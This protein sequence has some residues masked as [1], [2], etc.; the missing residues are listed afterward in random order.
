MLTGVLLRAGVDTRTELRG[1]SLARTE[2]LLI[3]VCFFVLD[4][5]FFLYNHAWPLTLF[6]YL[7]LALPLEI[8]FYVHTRRFQRVR[9]EAPHAHTG[10]DDAREARRAWER[11]LAEEEP[12]AVE[13]GLRSWFVG[14]GDLYHDDVAGLLSFSIYSAHLDALRQAQREVILSLVKMVEAVLGHY[15]APGR[16]PSQHC[17]ASHVVLD[18]LDACNKPLAFYVFMQSFEA[19]IYWLFRRMG[20]ELR[21]TPAAPGQPVSCSLLIAG[22]H[23]RCPK[24]RS[25]LSSFLPN[26]AVH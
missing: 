4:C 8:A 26:P 23:C 13:Q 12:E 6:C 18:G 19:L 25:V 14:S 20:F 22:P 9:S 10:A 11:V 2:P 5:F 1:A 3:T 24:R 15:L 7:P 17:L 16:N 21:C